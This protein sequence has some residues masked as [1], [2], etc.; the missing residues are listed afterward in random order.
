LSHSFLTN[1]LLSKRTRTFFLTV[2]QNSTTRRIIQSYLQSQSHL[3]S[4]LQSHKKF[5]TDVIVDGQSRLG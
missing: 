3:Q 2:S 4:H 5:F 1:W